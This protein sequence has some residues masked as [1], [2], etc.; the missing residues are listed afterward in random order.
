VNRKL[1]CLGLM[2]A[3]L[4]ATQARAQNTPANAN[5]VTIGGKAAQPSGGQTCVQAQIGNEKP[6]PYDCLNQKL[7][8]QVQ[9]ANPTQPSVPL[10]ATSPSNQVGT[11]NEQGV[12]QQYGQNFGK[13]VVPYRPPAPVFS[14]P[15]HP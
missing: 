12:K 11:F 4:G 9:G 1:L 13:S 3:F 7:Q 8:Q 6:S 2:A 10:G 15:V 5:G 14:N